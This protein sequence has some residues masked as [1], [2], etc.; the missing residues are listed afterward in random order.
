MSGFPSYPSVEQLL[1]NPKV[2]PKDIKSRYLATIQFQRDFAEKAL[3]L[4]RGR[5]F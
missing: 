2:S 3:E 1:G 5:N 4:G